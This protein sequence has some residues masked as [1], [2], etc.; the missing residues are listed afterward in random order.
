MT[1]DEQHELLFRIAKELERRASLQEQ[2][3]ESDWRVVTFEDWRSMADAIDVYDNDLD[4]FC[5][6]ATHRV[7]AVTGL[8]VYEVHVTGGLEGPIKFVVADGTFEWVEA[9]R[10]EETRKQFL[11]EGP[12]VE[13]S[14]AE[15][16][17][18][19][20]KRD[21]VASRPRHPRRRWPSGI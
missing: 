11:A 5:K 10:K 6:T 17:S 2:E 13:I 20:A 7:V 19:R 4:M 14:D 9:Q 21:A 8:W 18:V 16:A 15:L 3:G 1:V 12:G